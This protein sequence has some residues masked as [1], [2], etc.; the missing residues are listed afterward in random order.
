MKTAF[1]RLVIILAF[2]ASLVSCKLSDVT[3]SNILDAGKFLDGNTFVADNGTRYCLTSEVDITKIDLA[4][5]Y[6]VYYD[7]LSTKTSSGYDYNIT[8][9]EIITIDKERPAVES[10]TIASDTI[11]NPAKPISGFYSGQYLNMNVGYFRMKNSNVAHSIE[12]VY[13]ENRSTPTSLV[14]IFKHKAFGDIP[15]TEEDEENVESV[16]KLMSFYIGD[17][18]S[19]YASTTSSYTITYHYYWYS[20]DAFT[21]EVE[22]MTFN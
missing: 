10:S 13:D 9:K 7:L 12:L 4:Q 6:V 19:K 2:C 8:M 16:T 22:E 1:K 15:G 21:G 18:L 14:F 11:Y 20:N 17:I 5:R 3:R